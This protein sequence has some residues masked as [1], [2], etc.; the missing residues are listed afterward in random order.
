MCVC[1]PRAHAYFNAQ[2]RRHRVIKRTI[3]GSLARSWPPPL[4]RRRRR[5]VLL[6]IIVVLFLI[7]VCASFVYSVCACSRTYGASSR[8]LGERHASCDVL[9][10]LLLQLRLMRVLLR[11]AADAAAAAA[12][13]FAEKYV[14]LGFL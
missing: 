3:E 9:L 11:T 13:V 14:G 4:P 6:P 12:R 8:E 10:S 5:C 1:T 7:L 2:P